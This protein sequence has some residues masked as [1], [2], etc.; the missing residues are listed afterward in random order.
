MKGLVD[1]TLREGGQTV[2]VTFDPAVK[3]EIFLHL[4]RVGV[5]EIELGCATS[6]APELVDFMGFCRRTEGSPRLALWSR[7][8]RRDIALACELRPDVLS[9]SIPASD[10]HLEKKL[11]RDRG[12]ALAAV[13]EGVSMARDNGVALVSLGLEDATRADGGFVLQLARAAKSA[14]AFR[15]RIAD[16]VGC[17]TPGELAGM[18]GRLK[19]EIP[20]EVG[21]HCH[22]DF[23]MATANSIMA[24]DAGADW[25]D[26]TVLGLGER[27]GCAGLEAVAVFLAFRRGRG[28]ETSRLTALAK[29][30]ACA[31][32]RKIHPH[33]PVVG[34]RI[35]HCETGLH[36]QGLMR[37]PA[38]YEPFPP[39]ATGAE[40][41]FAFGVKSGMKEVAD[42]L[43]RGGADWGRVELERLTREVRKRAAEFGRSLDA[44][45]FAIL[46]ADAADAPAM[47]A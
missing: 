47:D 13:G 34:E 43:G 31:S 12:W 3:K 41:R 29:I 37:D 20:I 2:G 4:C 32:G 39:E 11:A 19:K 16:T 14:G 45:E 46:V 44:G 17:A 7:C 23:A 26:V 27:A 28:Y 36:L 38:T 21:V 5:E 35:F 22:N 33:C 10:L 15:V 30:V 8:R 40:R 1:T 6:F 42:V 9:L 24:L 25:A 18:V